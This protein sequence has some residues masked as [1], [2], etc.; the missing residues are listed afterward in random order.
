MTDCAACTERPS[1]ASPSNNT[2]TIIAVIAAMTFSA[3]GAAPTPL[4]HQYQENLGLTPAMVTVIFAAYVLSLLL[5]LLTTGALS[6]HI[7]CRPVILGALTLN[8]VAMVMFMT[9][10]SAAALIAARAVQGFATGVATTALGAAILD[11]D[12]S[13]RAHGISRPHRRAAPGR[14]CLWRGRNRD[15]SRIAAGNE[16]F[17][18]RK[19]AM[20][21]QGRALVSAP[22]G[23]S[24]RPR[25]R[26]ACWCRCR[27]SYRRGRPHWRW[28]GWLAWAWRRPA[29]W[30]R[31]RVAPAL[32]A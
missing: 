14:R 13:R 4:Y 29:G 28:R 19:I 17:A 20:P 16:R 21:L 24:D 12:R 10:D 25:G 7:G 1:R 27:R 6:D 23:R 22:A 2:T 5:A 31:C 32:P 3:C 8:I 9:A 18:L 26:G 30:G 15:G 11:I